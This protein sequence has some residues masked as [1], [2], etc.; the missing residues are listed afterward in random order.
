MGLLF[1]RTPL[2]TPPHSPTTGTSLKME[3]QQKWNILKPAIHHKYIIYIKK[4]YRYYHTQEETQIW[5]LILVLV[6]MLSCWWYW[7]MSASVAMSRRRIWLRAPISMATT[8]NRRWRHRRISIAGTIHRRL[9]R[10]GPTFVSGSGRLGR[11]GSSLGWRFRRYATFL[12]AR[13]RWRITSRSLGRGSITR[14]PRFLRFIDGT[15]TRTS[16]SGHRKNEINCRHSRAIKKIRSIFI[17][18]LNFIDYW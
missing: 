11:H 6:L 8:A 14:W 4:I 16:R 13:R 15:M 9:W 12:V 1:D 3:L 5:C 10:N 18:K 2:P 7:R 17:D